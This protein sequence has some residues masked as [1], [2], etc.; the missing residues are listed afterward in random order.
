MLSG[1]KNK[2]N[3]QG[4]WLASSFIG[5]GWLPVEE[6]LSKAAHLLLCVLRDECEQSVASWI[7]AIDGEVSRSLRGTKSSLCKGPCDWEYW[8]FVISTLTCCINFLKKRPPLRSC[9]LLSFESSN[10]RDGFLS[11]ESF[12]W[13]L[14]RITQSYGLL[15]IYIL[16]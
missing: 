11:T 14:N 8:V 3:K 5:L 4:V 16:I 2:A 15:G 6:L 9:E 1:C 12:N 13:S 7:R 10:C